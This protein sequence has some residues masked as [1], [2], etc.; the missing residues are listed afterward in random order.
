MWVGKKNRVYEAGN[1]KGRSGEWEEVARDRMEE[2]LGIVRI[3]E[4]GNRMGGLREGQ[5]FQMIPGFLVQVP[6]PE[7]KNTALLCA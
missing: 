3:W 2:Y 7:S 1:E 5:G 4:L 6:G